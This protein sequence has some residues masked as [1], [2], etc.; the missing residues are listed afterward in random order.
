VLSGRSFGRYTARRLSPVI[1]LPAGSRTTP[2]SALAPS[3]GDGSSS[4]PGAPTVPVGSTTP[5]APAAPADCDGDGIPNAQD[6]DDDNDLLPDDTE[7]TL[8]TDPCLADTD[9]DGVDDGFEYRSAVD[10]NDDDFQ[11]PNTSL[12]YP[13]KR[14]YPNPLDPSDAGTDYDGDSLTLSEEQS[15]WRYTIANGAPRD[16]AQL[17]YSDGEQ[18]TMSVRAANGRRMPTLGAAG[19]AKQASFLSWASSAGYRQVILPDGAPWY[20]GSKQNS[21]GLLDANRDGAES[22]S[23]LPGYFVAESTYYDVNQDGW[24]SD[25]ERD[26]D[27]DGLTNYDELHGRMTPG[28]WNSC[29]GER[30]FPVAYAGTSPTDPDSDGDGILDGADDQDHDGIPNVMELSR[31]AGSGLNDIKTG[32]SWCVPADGLT[33]VNHPDAYG[34]VNPFNPCLPADWSRTCPRYTGAWAPSDGSPNW[35][36]LN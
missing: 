26:E 33:D 13:G 3:G 32:R 24:L 30:S 11:Q 12:P 23:R 9:H 27:G 19:Y 18:Y 8:G 10:L 31:V 28:F 36:S 25:D 4:S 34:R 22:T 21:Y 14:P 7:K 6:S 15:L 16:L 1:L 20:D 35:Y 5:A 29:Y 17:T 2:P